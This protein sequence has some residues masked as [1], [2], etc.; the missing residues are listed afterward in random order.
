MTPSDEP[1][2]TDGRAVAG[3]GRGAAAPGDGGDRPAAGVGTE[4]DH[5][6]IDEH[7]VAERYALGQLSADDAA[8]FEEHSL[9]CPECLDRLEAADELRLGLRHLAAEE[10]AG[11]V[12]RLGL[13]A[14]L[15]RSRAA[16]WAVAAL[17][18]IALLP[19]GLLLREVGERGRSLAEAR[20]ALEARDANPSQQAPPTAFSEAGGTGSAAEI[21]ALR[22][23][24]A[25][26][27]RQAETERRERERLAAKLTAERADRRRPSVNVPIVPLALERSGAAAEP[28]TRV[29]LSPDAEWIVLALELEAAPG[30]RHRAV[31][32]GPGGTLW[33]S[34]DLR[35]DAAG[36][37]TI[38]LPAALLQP[39]VYTVE[40]AE[41]PAQG[42]PVPVGDLSFRVVRGES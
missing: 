30:A 42:E 25:A 31:L 1:G 34:A 6:Y 39:G 2:E 33:Q 24:A 22:T 28:T 29:A 41:L 23:A 32:R 40:A 8:R 20:A 11:T 7:Q 13:L 3:Y 19:S 4:M 9:A 37:L 5:T 21:A 16:P 35:S 26:A 27:A 10:A 12:L 14:R 38:A 17:V 15:A 18:L 36:T